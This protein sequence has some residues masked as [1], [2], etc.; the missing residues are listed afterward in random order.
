MYKEMREIMDQIIKTALD[1]NEKSENRYKLV[2]EIADIAKKLIDEQL[3]K[4]Q[5]D[6]FGYDNE[7][8]YNAGI[9]KEKPVQHA[10]IVKASE[11]DESELVG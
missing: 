9:K 6:E 1:L 11:A 7:V 8:T 5:L 4:N 2:Y 3:H 10:I